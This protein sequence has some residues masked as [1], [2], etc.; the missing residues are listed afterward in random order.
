MYHVSGVIYLVKN[1]E[2]CFGALVKTNIWH[3]SS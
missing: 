2:R 1:E 3:T